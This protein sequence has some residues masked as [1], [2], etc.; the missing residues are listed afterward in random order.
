MRAFEDCNPFASALYFLTAAGICMFSESPVIFSLSLFGALILYIVRNG[1]KNGGIH[2][3]SLLLFVVMSLANPLFSHNG[4]T[5]LFVIN[6]NPVTLEAFVYGVFASVMIIS[7]LYWFSSFS[8]I[9]T[10]DK[11]LYIF[12]VFS[13]KLAL[14]LSMALRYVPLFEKQAKNVSK[15]QKALGIYREDNITDRFKGGVRVFS[16][17]VTWALENGI[18]TADSMRARGYG[19]GRR[20]HFSLFRFR[21]GDILLLCVSAVVLFVVL[22]CGGE[23]KFDFYPAISMPVTS[24]AGVVGYTAYGVLVLLPTLIEIKEALRWKYLKSKI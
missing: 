6:N 12:S 3:L 15:S 19:I 16:V 8:Q 10:S 13:P 5:V 14:M 2:M 17:M 23:M 24:V 18:I 21:L 9:M 11:L 20:S 22:L 4:V 7:V 1:I